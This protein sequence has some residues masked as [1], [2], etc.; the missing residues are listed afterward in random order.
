MSLFRDDGIVP[1]TRRPGAA[2][3]AAPRPRTDRPAA[4]ARG[5]VR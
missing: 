1:P 3:R 5:G 4:T 2:D